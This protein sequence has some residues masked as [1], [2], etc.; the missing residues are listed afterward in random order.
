M[1]CIM[2]RY[3]LTPVL[4]LALVFTVPTYAADK[5]SGDATTLHGPH[6]LCFS[7]MSP[8]TLAML[9]PERQANSRRGWVAQIK[10][11]RDV[12]G[13]GRGVRWRRRVWQ[14]R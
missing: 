5:S 1:R 9:S 14:L 6:L 11:R 7:I 13:A 8:A 3:F 12:R 2:P 4:L 10:L